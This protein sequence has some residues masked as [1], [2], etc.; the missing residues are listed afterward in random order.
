MY[1][2]GNATNSII[3]N[4]IRMYDISNNSAPTN[5]VSN[6]T[7]NYAMSH[8]SI[9]RQPNHNSI[10][11]TPQPLTV[12]TTLRSALYY[13]QPKPVPTNYRNQHS[14]NTPH[15]QFYLHRHTMVPPVSIHNTQIAL[16]TCNQFN[17]CP[18]QSRCAP[19]QYIK[20]KSYQIQYTTKHVNKTIQTS[21]H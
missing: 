19:N 2:S 7:N 8:E 13:R 15:Q 5:T 18:Q 3:Q 21:A 16:L 14:P 12:I 20:H 9:T 4:N 10:N 1:I 17:R 11:H 6:T